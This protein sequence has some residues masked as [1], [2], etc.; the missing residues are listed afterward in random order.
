[1]VNFEMIMWKIAN[2]ANKAFLSNVSGGFTPFK[3][4][5]VSIFILLSY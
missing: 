2:K 1:M 4:C 5:V 3:H